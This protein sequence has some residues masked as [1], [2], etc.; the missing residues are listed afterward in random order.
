MSIFKLLAGKQKKV[1]PPSKL[2]LIC[3]ETLGRVASIEGQIAA[4]LEAASAARGAAAAAS[5]SARAAQESAEQAQSSMEAAQAAQSAVD[6]RVSEFEQYEDYA[7]Y[8]G[9][10]AS[11]GQV[12]ATE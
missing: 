5:G 12:E 3:E 9:E 4:M 6:A 8:G 10:E 7:P 1:R 11:N 2:F